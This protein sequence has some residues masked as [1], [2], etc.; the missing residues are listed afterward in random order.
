MSRHRRRRFARLRRTLRR[1]FAAWDRFGAAIRKQVDESRGDAPLERVEDG[2]SGALGGN[3]PVQGYGLVD[4]LPWYFRARGDHW[5]FSVAFAADGDPVLVTFGEAD[6]FA[7]DE[8]YGEWPDAG[9]MQYRE[10]W[11]FI[12]RGIRE[13]RASREAAAATLGEGT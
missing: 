9:W 12:E 1:T 10:A 8:D 5:S 4:G 7:I 13:F 6:G 3:C 11:G 2:W